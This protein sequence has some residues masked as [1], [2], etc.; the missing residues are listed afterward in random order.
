[1]LHFDWFA[2]RQSTQ[3]IP[4]AHPSHACLHTNRHIHITPNAHLYAAA[5]DGHTDP[6]HGYRVANLHPQFNINTNNH[7]QPDPFAVHIYG[8]D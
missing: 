6:A 2:A 5:A 1:M 7:P 3:S 8:N 4:A